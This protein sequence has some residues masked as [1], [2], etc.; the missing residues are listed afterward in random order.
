MHN[1]AIPTGTEINHKNGIKS[2][3]RIEN[4]ELMTRRQNAQHA[5]DTGLNPGAYGTGAARAK[6]SSTDVDE[7][8]KLLADGVLQSCIAK[9]FGVRPNQISRIK[10]G[11]R[12]AHN[13]GDSGMNA[14]YYQIA[15]SRTMNPDLDVKQ[16]TSNYAMGLAGEAGEVVEPLKKHLYHGHSLDIGVLKKELGDVLF[17]VAAL[18]NTWGVDMGEAMEEN[19]AKLAK[20]YPNGFSTK[21]SV[22]RKA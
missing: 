22:E 15:V 12:R 2:D 14:K 1:G 4:L 20:R 18:C 6:L 21:A 3:N 7:I 5:V 11:A 19:I 16:A 9:Q 8:R 13:K 17:Y 10:T